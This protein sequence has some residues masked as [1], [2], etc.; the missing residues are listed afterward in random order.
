MPL[1]RGSILEGATGKCWRWILEHLMGRQSAESM[2]GN[3]VAPFPA[4]PGR[5]GSTN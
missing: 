2:S 1:L 5:C 3:S 4:L